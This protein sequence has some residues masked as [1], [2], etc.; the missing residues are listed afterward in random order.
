MT[1]MEV[2]DENGIVFS[3]V[4]RSDE[5]DKNGRVIP[6]EVLKN[7]IQDYVKKNDGKVL[8]HVGNGRYYNMKAYRE[9]LALHGNEFE[10][11]GEKDHPVS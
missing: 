8:V 10:G 9:E 11:K 1:P 3:T 7:A 4:L 2:M 5:P 6:H